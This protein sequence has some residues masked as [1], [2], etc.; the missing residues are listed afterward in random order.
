M[1]REILAVLEAG[2]DGLESVV[3]AAVVQIEVS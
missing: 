3:R 2:G 1:R